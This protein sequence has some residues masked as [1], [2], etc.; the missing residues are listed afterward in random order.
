MKQRVVK[1]K[2]CPK[3]KTELN[4]IVGD[5]QYNGIMGS[6]SCPKCKRMSWLDDYG[7]IKKL[8]DSK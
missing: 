5:M 1:N 7:N 6:I 3:C 8:I 2:F 4:I